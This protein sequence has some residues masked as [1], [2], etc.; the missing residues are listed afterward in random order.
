MQRGELTPRGTFALSIA[1]SLV[2]IF[3][4]W[5]SLRAHFPERNTLVESAG[6]VEWVQWFKGTVRFK[7]TT[8]SRNFQY[9]SKGGNSDWVYDSLRHSNG[10]SVFVLVDASNSWKPM[11]SD[12][13]YFDVYEVTISGRGEQ[14]YSDVRSSWES[15]NS[16]GTGLGIALL[17]LGLYLYGKSRALHK[18]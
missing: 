1:T 18:T 12:T 7:L 5:F 14:H 2:G 9:A 8:D 15:D 10:A 17:L 6:K 16:V 3:I 13:A 11:F 4:I